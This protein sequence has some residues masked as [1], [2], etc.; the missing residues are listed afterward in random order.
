MEEV[1]EIWED[2]KGYE[3]LYQVSN[4]GNIKSFKRYKDGKLMKLK[5]DKDGYKEIGIRDI[6]GVRKFKR[7]HRLVCECF[8]TKP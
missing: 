8:F 4:L 6:N 3:G 2:I 5:S 1:E 7:V